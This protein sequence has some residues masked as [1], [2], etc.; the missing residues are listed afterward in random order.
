MT[1]P[2]HNL[3]TLKKQQRSLVQAKLAQL[4]PAT[5]QQ[6]RQEIFARLLRILERFPKGLCLSYCPLT[7]EPLLAPEEFLGS[8]QIKMA[9]PRVAGDGLEFYENQRAFNSNDWVTNAFGI[10]E[11]RADDKTCWRQIE[12]ATE[13]VV[14]VIVPALAADHSGA[15]LGRGKGFYDRFLSRFAG[16]NWIK[17]CALFN[18]QIIETIQTEPWDQKMDV[19]VTESESSWSSQTFKRITV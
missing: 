14:G 16:K 10:R 15:R 7:T 18:E 8:T 2:A 9:W 4:S 5:A 6:K 1:A 3:A 12:L 17:I 19:L 13:P 11:P